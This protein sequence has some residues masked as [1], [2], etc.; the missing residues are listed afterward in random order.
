M[1]KLEI[2]TAER[3]YNILEYSEDGENIPSDSKWVCLSGDTGLLRKLKEESKRLAARI[4]EESKGD[5]VKL[6]AVLMAAQTQTEI[7]IGW[8]GV[9]GAG[10]Q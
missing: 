9:E 10:K 4:V 7:I 5:N 8:L 6:I 2:K 1:A 3:I